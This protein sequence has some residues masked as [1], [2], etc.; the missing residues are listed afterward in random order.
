M[1]PFTYALKEIRKRKY[2]TVVNI[3][4][5]VIAISTLITLVMAARGWAVC[6][7][8]PLNS[9]GTDIILI[10]TAPIAPANTGCYIANHLFAYPFNQTIV[11]EMADVSGVECAVPIMMHRMRAIV[12][13]GIDPGETQTN[14]VLPSDVIDGRYLTPDDGYVALVE[15]EYAQLNNL[16]LGSNVTYV[17]T[18]EVVGIVDVSATNLIKSHIYLNLPTVQEVLPGKPTG[19]VNIALIRTSNPSA[20]EKTALA[21]EDKWTSASTLT[22]SD[23]AETASGVIRIGEETAWNIS[24]ALAV[25]SIL[26]AIKS[27]LGSVAERTREIGILK[28]IGWSNSNVVNQITIESIIQGIIGGILGCALG[29]VFASYVL[30]TIGGEI[31]GALRFITIDPMLL[32][33]GFGISV[34]SGIVAGLIPSLRAARLVPAE[35]LRTV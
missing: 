16:T 5:F 15:Y 19:L 20:V 4:G 25:V 35:A 12:V 32:G 9:I 8:L 17:G 13:T 1:I 10:Y 23:L 27:Q 24:V 31:G 29:Y 2:R 30:S 33:L 18:F 7:S 22:G 3:L 26:F 28:A 6:T 21:L 11:S 34:L 14:A